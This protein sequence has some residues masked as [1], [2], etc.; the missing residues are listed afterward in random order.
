LEEYKDLVKILDDN[1]KDPENLEL[2]RRIYL[3]KDIPT[4]IMGP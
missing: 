3:K 4:L 1:M 2:R